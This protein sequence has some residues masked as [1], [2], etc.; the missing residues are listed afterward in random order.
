MTNYQLSLPL[1]NIIYLM[2]VYTYTYNMCVYIHRL[3]VL[4]RGHVE[5][6]CSALDTSI[7]L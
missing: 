5:N 1:S 6:N 3:K 2:R 4:V 7:T